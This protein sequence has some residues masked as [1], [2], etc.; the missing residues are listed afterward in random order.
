MQAFLSDNLLLQFVLTAYLLYSALVKK[1]ITLGDFV[2]VFNGIHVTV[3]MVNYLI[4]STFTRFKDVYKRQ[5][6]I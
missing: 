4:G 6:I 3:S 2:A 1:T 5:E